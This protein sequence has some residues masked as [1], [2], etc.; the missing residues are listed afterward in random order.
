MRKGLLYFVML[1]ERNIKQEKKKENVLY[2]DRYK[3]VIIIIKMVK[4]I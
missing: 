4:Y 3:S 1:T 2:T